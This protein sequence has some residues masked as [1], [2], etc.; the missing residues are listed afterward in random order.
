[1]AWMAT[2]CEA[3]GLVQ[4]AIDG[5]AVL[6]AKRN[7]F[8]GRLHLVS[9]W[10]AENRLILG[11]AAVPDLGSEQ[12]ALPALLKVLDLAGAAVTIDGGG[13]PAAGGARAL[14][15]GGA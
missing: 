4:I 1:A 9:A 5:K 2:A 8:S 13:G 7:T 12:T 3:A 15:R 14:G 6:G 11:Q 10:A